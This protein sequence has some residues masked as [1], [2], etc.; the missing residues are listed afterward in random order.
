MLIISPEN[1]ENANKI[2]REKL[3][4]KPN[5]ARTL[6]TAAAEYLAPALAPYYDLFVTYGVDIEFPIPDGTKNIAVMW[7]Q[8]YPWAA[9]I[10]AWRRV[11]ERLSGYT[12]DYFCNEETIVA[13]IREAGGRA[14]FLP[15]FI[16]TTTLPTPKPKRISNLWF[17]NRWGE[18]G[19][20]F[21]LFLNNKKPYWISQGV[22]GIGEK[23]IAE[24][25]HEQALE[26]VSEAKN[27]WA[28]GLCQLEAK[29]LGANVITYRGEPLP[30][31]D[32]NTIVDYLKDLIL[33]GK[34]TRS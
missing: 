14:F 23:E 27:V 8:N 12:V 3:D 22:F 34:K 9:G 32:Q 19:V 20:E 26:I 11:N 24:L 25:D 18:F 17:G 21:Q 15:R 6:G 4:C 10:T 7:H 13:L 2:W 1:H 16:D 33:G 28:I 5:G 31:Y 29:A 30:F